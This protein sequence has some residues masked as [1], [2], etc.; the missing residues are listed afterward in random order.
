MALVQLGT[1]EMVVKT[2]AVPEQ[3]AEPLESRA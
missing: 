1:G 3:I 2:D